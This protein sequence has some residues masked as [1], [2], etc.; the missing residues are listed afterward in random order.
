MRP[1]P[2]R[3]MLSL[4]ACNARS[5]VDFSSVSRRRGLQKAGSPRRPRWRRLPTG[6]GQAACSAR[7]RL[8]LYSNLHV[9]TGT[10]GL[11]RK[12]GKG[13]LG[14]LPALSRPVF[15]ADKGP[16]RGAAFARLAPHLAGSTVCWLPA[17]RRG[18]RMH[19]SVGLKLSISKSLS[20]LGQGQACVPS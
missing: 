20:G 1:R 5:P 2:M 6:T 12:A 7:P 8:G 9:C 18:R 16:G 11:G 19:T 4:H 17:C 15:F 3:C 10:F 13:R 14:K